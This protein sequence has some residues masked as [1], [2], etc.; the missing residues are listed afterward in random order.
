MDACTP[1]G[2]L[3]SVYSFTAQATDSGNGTPS[4]GLAIPTLVKS[5]TGLPA[6]QPDLG[7]ASLRLH[8][9]VILGYVNLTKTIT[10]TTA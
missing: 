4:G 8:S 10:I 6:D 1:T 9:G 5:L 2:P 3:T 7:N